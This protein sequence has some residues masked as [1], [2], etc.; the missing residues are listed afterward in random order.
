MLDAIF[1]VKVCSCFKGKPKEEHC[2]IIG[3]MLIGKGYNN[4]GSFQS[5][6]MFALDI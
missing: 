3:G 5:K 1:E 4:H 2:T 6:S